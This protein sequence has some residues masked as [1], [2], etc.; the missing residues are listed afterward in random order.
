MNTE[1]TNQTDLKLFEITF[2]TPDGGGGFF[3][4]V[5]ADIDGFEDLVATVAGKCQADW[6]FEEIGACDEN[7]E[8]LV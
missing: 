1:K 2:V 7:G 6:S 5:A 8:L 3:E 4:A